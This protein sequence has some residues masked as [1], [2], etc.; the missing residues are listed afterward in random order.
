MFDISKA[1]IEQDFPLGTTVCDTNGT[2]A[3]YVHAP[4][5]SIS[6]Y[7]AVGFDA[8]F[9]A[10][11]LAHTMAYDCWSVGFAQTA[12]AVDEYGW[13]VV[14]GGV[15]LRVKIAPRT[16][17]GTDLYT[18]DTPGI[19]SGCSKRGIL[20]EGVVTLQSSGRCSEA[21]PMVA[22]CPRPAPF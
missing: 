11:P 15:N 18:S 1:T 20:I 12:I 9:R 5:V 7:Q 4:M 16:R 19:L 22:T 3:I 8:A 6:A 17:S 21:V 13:L 10:A 14:A 2:R